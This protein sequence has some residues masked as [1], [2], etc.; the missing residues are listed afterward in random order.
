MIQEIPDFF[1]E[2]LLLDELSQEKKEELLKD[3]RTTRRLK[4]LEESNR[5]IREKY[6]FGAL[7]RKLAESPEDEADIAVEPKVLHLP[8][9]GES[10]GKSHRFRFLSLTAP[11]LA[12]A[13]A[14]LIVVLPLVNNP[15]VPGSEDSTETVRLKGLKPQL[16]IYRKTG[17]TVE[18]LKP[19]Q[20]VAARDLLQL[21]YQGAG[22]RYGTIFSID[23]NGFITLHYPD[24][25]SQSPELTQGGEV[26]L[27]FAYQLD[28]APGFERFFFVVSDSYF[29]VTQV[30]NS[31][32]ALAGSFYEARDGNLP[33]PEVCESE[34]IL[35]IKEGFHD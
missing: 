2:Q 6:D 32:A 27:D 21:S 9:S 10:L 19:N 11:V 35:L 15:S 13:A 7:A 28:D 29:S 23:G 33:L 31:A 3:P 4:D 24:S 14:L 25:S 12:A 20:K 16:N 1:L 26:P 34:S 17:N 18:L 22:K 8:E 30:L 5:Q